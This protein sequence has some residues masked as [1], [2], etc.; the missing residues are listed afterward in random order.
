MFYFLQF[1]YRLRI[2]RIMS[3]AMSFATV[4]AFQKSFSYFTK[5]FID[6]ELVLR[7]FLLWWLLFSKRICASQADCLNCC[8][9]LFAF[10]LASNHP[11]KNRNYFSP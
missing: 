9:C 1:R 3:F 6:P 4:L 10:Y 2:L 11:T 5:I 7:Q 8:D